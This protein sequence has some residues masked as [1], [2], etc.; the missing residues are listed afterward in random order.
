MAFKHFF[1]LLH[2]YNTQHPVCPAVLSE[3][4]PVSFT[5]F[6]DF[7]SHTKPS[8]CA[9]DILPTCLLKEVFDAV[10]T[11]ISFILNSSLANGSVP[12]SLKHAVEQP[13]LKKPNINASVLNNFHTISK[14]PFLSKV[15]EKM[16]YSQLLT[17]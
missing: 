11:T 13:I 16:V 1:T 6:K 14:L 3:F 12:P 5:Q 10:G 17:F 4:E 8:T 7:V 2:Q 9:L 15:P